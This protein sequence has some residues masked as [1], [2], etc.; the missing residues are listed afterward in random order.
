MKP[1][2]NSINTEVESGYIGQ[3]EILWQRVLEQAFVDATYDGQNRTEQHARDR[4]DR[5]I[6]ECGKDFRWV[7]DMAG[8]GAE[9]LSDRYKA[10]QVN[11]G[12]LKASERAQRQAA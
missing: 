2:G 6:R 11:R 9:F 10:G 3:H 4:A 7:C 5:W 1:L 8:M 12:L